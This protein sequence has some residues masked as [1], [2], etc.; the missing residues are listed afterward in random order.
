MFSFALKPEESQPGMEKVPE[1]PVETQEQAIENAFNAMDT[2][3]DGDISA[4]EL[5]N[6]VLELR[7]ANTQ[8]E[9]RLGGMDQRLQAL[10]EGSRGSAGRRGA[11][12][13]RA[14]EGGG[15]AKAKALLRNAMAM[16][17]GRGDASSIRSPGRVECGVCMGAD[18]RMA[19]R[20]CGFVLDI[21]AAWP[22]QDVT[23]LRRHV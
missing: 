17:R 4:E 14:A 1:L 19:G 15:R 16:H 23:H 10:P 18:G 7:A 12:F 20:A 9:T 3:G 22:I 11:P 5:L 21:D 6:G 13:D 2:N 8:L